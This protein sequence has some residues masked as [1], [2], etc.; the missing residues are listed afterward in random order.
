MRL[1]LLYVLIFSVSAENFINITTSGEFYNC[2]DTCF[3]Q[4][5]TVMWGIPTIN[6]SLSGLEF[7]SGSAYLPL[8]NMASSYI[9]DLIHNNFPITGVVP[10]YVQL[11]IT[12]HT[13]ERVLVEIPFMLNIHETNNKVS[14]SHPCK[15]A[16]APEWFGMFDQN[17]SLCCPYYT[18][19]YPCSDRIRFITPFN[20]NY[21]FI[22]GETNYTLYIDGFNQ[23]TN[24]IEDTFITQELYSTVGKIYARL[25]ALCADNTTCHSNECTIGKCKEGYCQYNSTILNGEEC[26]SD[27]PCISAYCL[28]GEC[29]TGN[30]ICPDSSDNSDDDDND[31]INLLP[32]L[33]LVS[34]CCYLIP[35]LICCC[36]LLLL[37]PLGIILLIKTL[38]GAT[39]VSAGITPLSPTDDNPLYE[40]VE[41]ICENPV[42]E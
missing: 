34:L 16:D 6:D 2:S 15:Y 21:S 30:N 3:I 23:A 29:I 42:Y 38:L 19:S 17:T 28:N 14:D 18:K 1:L 37:I 7:Q 11:N 40:C 39:S 24:W 25:I 13:H 32:L 27:D 20:I 35:L 36:C 41:K 26:Y 12:I 22:V 4:N 33:S 10:E 9:G 5:N 31:D 8:E